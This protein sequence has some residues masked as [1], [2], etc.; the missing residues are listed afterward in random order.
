MPD[1]DISIVVPLYNEEESV[2]L[3]YDSITN[4]MKG[5][6]RKYEIIF[7]DDGST[8][9]TFERS[10]VIHKKDPHLKVIRFRKNY[11]QTPAMQAGFEHSK[12]KIVISMDGDLQNDPKDI[13]KF[14]EKIEEGYDIVCGW[15][16]DRKD[17][18]I[19]RKIPSKVANWIIGQVTGVKIHD[20]GC[21]LK[22]YRSTAIKA[23][24]L[25][26]EM[27]RFIPAMTSVIGTRYTE[28]VV[29]HHARKFGISKYGLSRIWKVFLDI[30]VI[31]MLLGFSLSHGLWFGMLSLPF[32][33]LGAIFTLFSIDLYLNSQIYE[34]LPIIVPSIS[35]LFIFVF[36][37]LVLL[38]LLSE[39]I[40]KVG[41][42]RIKDMINKLST[43]IL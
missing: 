2:K 31:K 29:T 4:V 36:V 15:R 8:D 22:A 3:L 14:I 39:L 23:T 9:T 6:N 17:K 38:G 1:I 18:L 11:G 12:G 26:S 33:F 13:P 25:Y 43:K 20:N 30:F 16:K 34:T 5:L 32:L 7:V 40:Y 27:H 21:S 35:I 37:H 19:S 42:F 41:D 28:I 10:K 24:K